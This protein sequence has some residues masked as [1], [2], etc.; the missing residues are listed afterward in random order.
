MT[1]NPDA[2]STLTQEKDLMLPQIKL[3]IASNI[4]E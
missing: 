1:E 4:R 3:E 2:L